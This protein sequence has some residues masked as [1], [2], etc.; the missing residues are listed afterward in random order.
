MEGPALSKVSGA[1]PRSWE[2]L[3]AQIKE[4]Q[5]PYRP[6]GTGMNLGSNRGMMGLW[7][8]ISGAAETGRQAACNSP[9]KS[10]E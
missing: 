4:S 8:G 9:T 5:P 2:G 3:E 1:Y 6:R 7:P 10:M